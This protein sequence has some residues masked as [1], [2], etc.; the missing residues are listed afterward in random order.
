MDTSGRIYIVQHMGCDDIFES[1]L[2]E[3]VSSFK[4]L[5]DTTT[6][7]VVPPDINP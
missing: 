5:Y 2:L 4:V 3:A 6:E 1:D 7:T